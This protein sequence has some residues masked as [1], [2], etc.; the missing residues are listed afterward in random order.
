MGM[1]EKVSKSFAAVKE[2]IESFKASMNDWIVLLDHTSRD[3]K[4]QIRALER[5]V[6]QL[7]IEKE[8]RKFGDF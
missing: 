1:E 7:E 6:R 3:N 4:E 2:D 5:R 8:I